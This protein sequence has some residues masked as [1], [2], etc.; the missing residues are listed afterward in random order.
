MSLYTKHNCPLCAWYLLRIHRRP[1][2]RF[3]SLF[4]PVHRYRCSNAQCHWEGNFRVR[5]KSTLAVFK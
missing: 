3:L 2:D 4:I 1:K 5:N